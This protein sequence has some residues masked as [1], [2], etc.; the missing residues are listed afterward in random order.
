MTEVKTG[1]TPLEFRQWRIRMGTLTLQQTADVLG[2]SFA[3]VRCYSDGRRTVP[4][5]IQKLTETLEREK[6]RNEIDMGKNTRKQTKEVAAPQPD[7][8]GLNI[9]QLLAVAFRQ[10]KSIRSPVAAMTLSVELLEQEFRD[11][12][13][14]LSQ[15][16]VEISAAAADKNAG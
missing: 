11:A 4:P 7:M 14:I 13:E 1:M 16:G 15:N 3:T 2:S 10:V 9:P 8:P 5:Y 6:R 12:I